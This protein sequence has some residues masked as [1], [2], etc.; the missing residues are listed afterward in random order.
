MDD[1]PCTNVDISDITSLSIVIIF[2]K[3]HI[4]VYIDILY[5]YIVP[6]VI[7]VTGV[8]SHICIYLY[9]YIYI[10]IHLYLV[11]SGHQTHSNM[12]WIPHLCSGLGARS[13]RKW[14]FH[15]PQS[16]ETGARPGARGLDVHDWLR[17]RVVFFLIPKQKSKVQ[18]VLKKLIIIYLRNFQL[19]R[20]S[21]G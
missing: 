6:G 12:V 14:V 1:H 5:I 10:Y 3:P 7:Y 20:C 9:V 2:T 4:S 15:H 18:T 16:S 8:L 13:C 17:H 19:W 11:P 21:Q